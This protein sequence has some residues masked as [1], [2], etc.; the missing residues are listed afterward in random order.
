MSKTIEVQLQEANNKI[1]ELEAIKAEYEAKLQNLE[2][3]KVAISN[4]GDQLKSLVQSLSKKLE[5]VSSKETNAK[6][7]KDDVFIY[8]DETYQVLVPVISLKKDG[9]MEKVTKADIIAD[10]ELQSFLVNGNSSAIKKV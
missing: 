7:L 5:E 6:Q 1:C 8:N 4:E 3:D 10:A 9:K 2:A